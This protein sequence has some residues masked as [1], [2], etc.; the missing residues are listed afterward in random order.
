VALSPDGT[1]VV[2]W[3]YLYD[4]ATGKRLRTF[5]RPDDDVRALAFSPD[6][7]T[8]A[9]A[10]KD[11]PIRLWDVATARQVRHFGTQEVYSL[12]YSPDGKTLAASVAGRTVVLWDPATGSARHRHRFREHGSAP[13]R[14][15]AY[16]PDSALL[17]SEGFSGV[18]LLWDA[19][20]G[21]KFA[22]FRRDPHTRLLA[23]AFSPNG[24]TIASAYAFGDYGV[25]LWE[26]ATGRPRLRLTGH[27]GHV[28]C[29]A[30]SPDGKRLVTGSMDT[31]ALVWD[32]TQ[33][34]RPLARDG[35]LSDKQVQ[36]LWADLLSP[37]AARAYQ[38]M[39]ILATSPD[40]ARLLKER[41]R[42][43][44][45]GDDARINRL[46]TALDSESFAEREK[47]TR[48]LERLGAS[49]EGA[50]R[51]AL[52]SR[53]SLEVHRRLTRLLARF[54]TD[55]LRTQ[56]ALEALE[57]SGMPQ[58]QQVLEVLAKGAPGFR[59]TQEAKQALR[60]LRSAGK[61]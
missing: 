7:K 8:L 43:A 5:G 34:A 25:T 32:L 20:S 21:K 1:V 37:D 53:P 18:L 17:A 13:V 26:L 50:L 39:C 15:L 55:W 46:I 36:A 23:F 42:P 51:K 12:V 6:G 19:R 31:S 28:C 4:T 60:R 22:Q 54:S 48:E 61:R 56:R 27:R 38:A 29:L 9:L 16:S 57:L 3:K 40:G 33:P 52:Q 11:G 49:A 14:M 30:F 2:S 59:Q 44:R 24:K 10:G 35:K 47:A 45:A 58:A 41:L